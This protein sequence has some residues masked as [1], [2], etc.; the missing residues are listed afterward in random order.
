MY[1]V[2]NNEYLCPLIY[3]KVWDAGKWKTLI[4]ITKLQIELKID[5]FSEL[6]HKIVVALR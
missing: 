2:I 1:S 4:I 6:E 5:L 3:F